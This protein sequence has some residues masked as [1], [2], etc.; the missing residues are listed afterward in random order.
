MDFVLD[1]QLAFSADASGYLSDFEVTDELGET[2][3]AKIINSDLF[4][5][6]EENCDWQLVGEVED[7]EEANQVIEEF[8][9]R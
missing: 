4:V 9:R 2:G 7:A 5:R 3:A 1:E 6:R 8:W